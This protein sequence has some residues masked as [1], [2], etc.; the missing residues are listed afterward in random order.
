[1]TE[2]DF[3]RTSSQYRFWNFT[4]AKLASLRENTNAFAVQQ[5]RDA[6]RRHRAREKEKQN[7]ETN[8][9]VKK[10]VPDEGVDCLTA[11]EEEV[12]VQLYATQCLHAG[13]DSKRF[14]FPI[15]V[16]VS[17]SPSQSLSFPT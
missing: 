17:E 12:I 9:E 3:Y 11:E 7:G 8:G 4:P 6:I 1:M 10:P 5:V 15:E 16:V 14:G 2:D 13:L